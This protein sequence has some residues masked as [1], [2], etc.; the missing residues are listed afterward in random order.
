[1]KA[2]DYPDGPSGPVRMADVARLAGVARVTVSRVLS[3]PASVAPA[4]RVAVQEAIARLGYVPNLN[5]GTLASSRSRIV[6]CI[7][8][9]LSNAWFAETIDGLSEVLA[10]AG[11]QLL[12][13]QS[14]YGPVGEERLVDTFLGRRVDA[15]VLTGSERSEAV[16]GRLAAAGIP[17]VETWDLGLEPL[18]MAVGFSN[19]A[20]GEA[21]AEHLLAR[22]CR[23][24]AY[25]GIEEQR[26]AKRLEGFTAALARRDIAPACIDAG[27]PPTTFETGA[28]ALRELLERHP[29]IDG[30]FCSNDTLAAAALFECQRQGWAVPQKIAVVGFSDQP[31]AAATV[32][33]LTSVQV[34]S[35]ELGAEAGRM[36]LRRLGTVAAGRGMASEHRIADLGF[37]IVARE[38]A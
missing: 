16:R 32:P 10:A 4:T 28:R 6:G 30:V 31:I 1:M 12:L 5:A 19:Y 3:N 15:M 33:S 36:L 17:I 23:R 25:I 2:P 35:R 38:S 22:G 37:R 14:G 8:P 21:A 27:A 7:V 34:R 11:Y 29:S 13:G 24:P 18:D 26:S 9:T 20:A